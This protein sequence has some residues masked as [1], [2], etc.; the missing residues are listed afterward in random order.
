MSIAK[1]EH[2]YINGITDEL[3]DSR[4]TNFEISLLVSKIF[5]KIMKLKW[6]L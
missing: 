3:I 2:T 6:N 5:F 4:L 1:E